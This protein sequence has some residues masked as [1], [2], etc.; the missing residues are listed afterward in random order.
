ML[1]NNAL[2]R[3]KVNIKSTQARCTK[4]VRNSKDQMRTLKLEREENE[5]HVEKIRRRYE[6][7]LKS[8]E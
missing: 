1:E 8:G 4:A 6:K 7:E 3:E 2:K 5:Q